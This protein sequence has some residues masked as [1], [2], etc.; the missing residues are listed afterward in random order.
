[1]KYTDV[2]VETE[3]VDVGQCRK[4]DKNEQKCGKANCTFD[5]IHMCNGNF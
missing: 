5:N 3:D 4:S 1:M 2:D